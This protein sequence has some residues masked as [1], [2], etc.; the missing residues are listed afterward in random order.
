[1]HGFEVEGSV[2]ETAFS[3][4]TLGNA[5]DFATPAR[6]YRQGEGMPGPKYEAIVEQPML[7][8][9]R[10]QVVGSVPSSEFK[11]H[12]ALVKATL[13]ATGNDRAVTVRVK[14]DYKAA[15]PQAKYPPDGVWEFKTN[16]SRT[17]I[18]EITTA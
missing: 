16:M 8:Y 1:M 6:V 5:F 9:L 4:V 7:L 17:D 15:S 12:A 3:S 10:A 18:V 11:N 2:E 14:L 13:R